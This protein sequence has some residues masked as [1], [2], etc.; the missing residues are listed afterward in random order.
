MHTTD[1]AL[2]AVSTC[3]GIVVGFDFSSRCT[4]LSPLVLSCS[5]IYED[6]V[7]KATER[8]KS[9]VLG[10]PRHPETTLGP[11]V[12]SEQFE[13][14]LGYIE[15]GKQTG[16]R[17]ACG[18]ERHGNSGFFIKPTVFAGESV[19]QCKLAGAP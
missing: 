4:H 6:F 7:R 16:A 18:G 9:R 12:S 8:A 11:V 10:D 15:K 2:P 17:L 13:R 1:A 14:V 19:L 3:R 5:G